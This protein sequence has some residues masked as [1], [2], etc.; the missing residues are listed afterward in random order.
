MFVGHHAADTEVPLVRELGRVVGAA[1]DLLESPALFLEGA[2]TL[3]PAKLGGSADALAIGVGGT[4]TAVLNTPFFLFFAGNV[5]LGRDAAQVNEALEHM[6]QQDP[7]TWRSGPEDE[8]TFIFPKGTRVRA[9]GENLVWTIPGE[10]EVVQAAEVS[11][12]FSASEAIAGTSHRAQE[13]TWGMVVSFAANWRERDERYRT[14][15]I[16]HEFYHQHEQLRRWFRGFSIVYWPAYGYS[17]VT[18]GWDGHWAETRS[19]HAANAVDRALGSWSP[20]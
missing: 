11:L 5:D 15:T 1:G 18:R 10:E 6:E 16:I 14:V 2:V 20:D 7:A 19:G 8:R 3:S 17:Y 13:R 12:L 4:I 9:S